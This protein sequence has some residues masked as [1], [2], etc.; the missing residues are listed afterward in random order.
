LDL[1]Y[2]P[3]QIVLQAAWV[4]LTIGNTMAAQ[5]DRDHVE[6]IIGTLLKCPTPGVQIAALIMDEDHRWAYHQPLVAAQL[7]S[8]GYFDLNRKR[9]DFHSEANT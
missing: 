5:V 2:Q 7:G 1:A 4:H 8:G 6:P 3:G 9:A